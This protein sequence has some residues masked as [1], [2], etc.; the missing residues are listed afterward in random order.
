MGFSKR[1][2]REGCPRTCSPRFDFCSLLCRELHAELLFIEA[3]L[4]DHEDHE[5]PN[6]AAIW[7]SLV[8]ASDLLSDAHRRRKN[9]RRTAGPTSR[10]NKYEL[11]KADLVSRGIMPVETWP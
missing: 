6:P 11:L 9:M 10:I 7:S 8:E 5:G 4:R 1:C 2:P 3:W